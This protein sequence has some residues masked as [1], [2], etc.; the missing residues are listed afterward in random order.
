MKD[1]LPSSPALIRWG[2]NLLGALVVL[3]MLYAAAAQACEGPEL[4]IALQII[5]SKRGVGTD[6]NLLSDS[7]TGKIIGNRSYS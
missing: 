4:E 3:L 2:R 5:Q 1:Y 7:P 6:R